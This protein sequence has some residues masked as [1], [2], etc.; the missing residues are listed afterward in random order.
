MTEE[1]EKK[2]EELLG[3]KEQ[4]DSLTKE[5]RLAE[6]EILLKYEKQGKKS[7]IIYNIY[8]AL[9]L[10]MCIIGFFLIL[11][12][13]SPRTQA[14]ALI[15]FIFAAV[16]LSVAEIKHHNTKIKLSVLKELKQF[17]LRLIE[18]LKK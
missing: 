18:M 5:K 13:P 12:A 15:V 2:L 16:I 17:E 14:G 4:V 9:S 11:I 7:A 3:L 6:D 8:G 10:I 1:L